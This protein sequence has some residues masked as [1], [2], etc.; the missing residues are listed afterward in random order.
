[1]S[2][3]FDLVLITIFNI[4]LLYTVL[5]ISYAYAIGFPFSCAIPFSCWQII[6]FRLRFETFQVD[7]KIINLRLCC[8]LNGTVIKI[9]TPYLQFT[10]STCYKSHE[11]SNNFLVV[12]SK[13]KKLN[14]FF[15][16]LVW[17]CRKSRFSGSTVFLS[18]PNDESC[19]LKSVRFTP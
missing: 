15:F 8:T 7:I 4:I 17:I 18:Y 19:T 3:R 12:H 13:V 16:P 1:M 10:S 14:F 6:S 9:R 5:W 11:S 2:F